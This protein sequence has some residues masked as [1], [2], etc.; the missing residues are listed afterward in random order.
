MLWENWRLTQ[1]EAAQ[2]LV[3]GIVLTAAVVVGVAAFGPIGSSPAPWALGL[4]VM[5]Y[6]PRW[7]SVARLNGGRLMDGYP[8]YVVT[9]GSNTCMKRWRRSAGTCR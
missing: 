9:S 4:L 6:A 8:N 5:T 7:L 1:V 2:R 3:Q